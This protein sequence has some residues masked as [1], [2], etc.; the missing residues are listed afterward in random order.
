MLAN[1]KIIILALA[2]F[3][4]ALLPG[5]HSTK[6]SAVPT[7]PAEVQAPRERV[8]ANEFADLAATYG[9]WTDV[10]MPVRLQLTAP[11]NL[12]ISGTAKMR[13]NEFIHISVRF[14]GI[15]VGS[16][17]ADNDSVQIYAKAFD[18]IYYAESLGVLSQR[19]G[20][21]LGDLQSLML[22]QAF[23]AGSGTIKATD[24]AGFDIADAGD[25]IGAGVDAFSFSPKKL[26]QGIEW[27]YIAAVES[28]AAPVLAALTVK[29]QGAGK[30]VCVFG[31][32]EATPAGAVATSLEAAATLNGREVG[33]ACRLTLEN[34]KWNAGVKVSRPKI[35]AK[36]RRVDKATLLKMLKGL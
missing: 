18:D 5:C 1:H 25:I 30:L 15:E 24:A 4:V 12:S 9:T 22:G 3:V 28:G 7:P 14:F 21:T 17:Y 23:N 35:S 6:K 33:L 34:A 36:A 11:K 10:S 19:F 29:P 27:Q 16:L 20:L 26:P 32:P 13:R 2:A 8:L 31:A